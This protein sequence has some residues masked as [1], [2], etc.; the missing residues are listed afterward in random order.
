MPLCSEMIT[1][2]DIYD[3]IVVNLPGIN[4]MLQSNPDV[5]IQK[6]DDQW[7]VAHSRLPDDR[8]FNISDLGYY[9][10]PKLYGLMDT[11]S[12]DAVNATN[13]TSQPFLNSKGQGVIVGIIDTGIDYLSENF[14]DTAG[15][16]RIMAIWDQTLEYRQNLYVNYGRIYEQ[17]E[18]NTALEAYRNGLNPY[19]YV[20]TTDITGHGTFMAG[21]IASRKIDDYIGV[22]PE[23]SI[24]CVK[25]KNAKKYLRDYFYIRDDAVCFEE[26]DIMLAAR[27]LKDYAGLKKMP[28]VIY[29]GL[30][31][32]LGSRTGGSPLSNVLDSLTMHVNKL[33]CCSCWQ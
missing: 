25:L 29:M 20:G 5:C 14:C 3:Y 19:D 26:T 6:V 4:K 33:C 1:D 9:T 15:N 17:A 21:V 8:D 30:G 13:I 24:V 11:S 28:L 7:L 31:S 10:I 2:E 16:T 32:G 18:I 23:A 27:F 12:I 22:A